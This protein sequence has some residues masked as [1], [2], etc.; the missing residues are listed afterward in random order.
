MNGNSQS[1]GKGTVIFAVLCVVG[2]LVLLRFAMG[3]RSVSVGQ[4]GVITSYGTVKGEVQSGLHFIWPWE[5]VTGMNVRTVKDNVQAAAATKDL[6]QLDANVNLNYHLNPSYVDMVYRKVGTSYDVTIVQ[7]ALQEAVKANTAKFN[8][9]EEITNRATVESNIQTD[10][11]KK[12]QPWGINVDS[13]SIL[14]FGFSPQYSAA[15]ENKQVEQQNVAAA[16]YKLQQAQLNAQA[17]QAQ[18]SSLSQQILEQQAI[19]KWDGRMPQVVS[20]TNQ[21]FGINLQGQ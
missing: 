6:Q 11:T 15:I 3:I 7:P 17:N 12:L 13:L 1:S 16:Q 9:D 2:V 20:G 10:L 8:A 4:V 18:D 14:D 19:S 5:T 21:I